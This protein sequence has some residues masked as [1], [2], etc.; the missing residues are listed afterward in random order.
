MNLRKKSFTA[1][2]T[3]AL[4]AT[5][6]KFPVTT[7][8]SWSQRAV[9]SSGQ[10]WGLSTRVAHTLFPHS[11]GRAIT[12]QNLPILFPTVQFL[13]SPTRDSKERIHHDAV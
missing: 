5:K 3:E 9:L 1:S 8:R 4:E 12:S 2:L 7:H 13:C 10:S 11:N 6:A